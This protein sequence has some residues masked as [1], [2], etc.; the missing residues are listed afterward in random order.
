MSNF[1]NNTF[2]NS[3]AVFKKFHVHEVTSTL[4]DSKHISDAYSNT[5]K[6]QHRAHV[7]IVGTASLRPYD[8]IYLD[9][10]PNGMSG[11]W[12]V[13]SIKHIFGGQPANYML[14]LEV[15]TDIIGET[16]PKASSRSDIRDL[17]SDLANQSLVS[18]GAKLTEYSVS[19]NAS[20]LQPSY[21]NT[22]KTSKNI[23]TP[24]SVPSVSGTTIYKDGAP[25]ISGVKKT[26]Q[27]TSKSNGKVLL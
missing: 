17:Q 13:L 10:L 4:T 5:H 16:D 7:V 9:G 15:G 25:N 21:G 27:W 11:Y 23:S 22:T 2:T 12:T 1:S 20:S 3:K 6:Y 14:E 8:P 24:V 26:I 18:S 19:V